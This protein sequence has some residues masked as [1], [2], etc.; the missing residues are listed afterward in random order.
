MTE[1]VEKRLLRA[2]SNVRNAMLANKVN[3]PVMPSLYV[4]EEEL[5]RCLFSTDEVDDYAS[6]YREWQMKQ[7]AKG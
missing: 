7:P 5:M 3:A 6:S 2:L 1:H 4:V